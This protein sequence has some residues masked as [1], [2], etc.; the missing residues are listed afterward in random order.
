MGAIRILRLNSTMPTTL[1]LPLLL[2]ASFALASLGLRNSPEPSLAL[3][4]GNPCF[5]SSIVVEDP[6]GRLF[7]LCLATRC[8]PDENEPCEVIL[9]DP[10]DTIEVTFC[11]CSGMDPGGRTGWD[12]GTIIVSVWGGEPRVACDGQ[13]AGNQSC[14][15][16]S[17]IGFFRC[18][19]L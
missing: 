14:T 6:K 9:P 7:L 19:C 11:G 5:P 8:G 2:M 18:K 15:L 13:C 17:P 1:F 4:S 12:C 10:A 16:T 3:E